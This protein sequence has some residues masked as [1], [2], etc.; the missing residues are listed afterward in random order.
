MAWVER[1]TSNVERRTATGLGEFG[2]EENTLNFR[3]QLG[4]HEGPIDYL[5]RQMATSPHERLLAVTEASRRG[6]YDLI[7]EVDKW[8][9]WK[10][11]G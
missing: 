4:P 9:S 5:T 11:R 2:A 8:E 6:K 10:D 3:L 1:R 7:A